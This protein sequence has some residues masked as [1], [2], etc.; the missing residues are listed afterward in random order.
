MANIYGAFQ[1]DIAAA[2]AE[3]PAEGETPL[4]D[5]LFDREIEDTSKP[6][7]WLIHTLLDHARQLERRAS[8]LEKELDAC[9]EWS[10]KAVGYQGREDELKARIAAA[11]AVEIPEFTQEL[12]DF[13]GERACTNTLYSTIAAVRAKLKGE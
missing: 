1:K 10:A 12:I 3:V 5:A 9:K 13:A 8:E 7:T 4:T 11:L 2:P 6:A